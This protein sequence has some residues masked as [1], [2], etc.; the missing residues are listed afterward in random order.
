MILL[1]RSYTLVMLY[2]PMCGSCVNDRGFSPQCGL[3]E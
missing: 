2:M 1:Q 3:Y